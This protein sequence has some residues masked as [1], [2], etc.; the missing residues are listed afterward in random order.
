[1]REG[2]GRVG[3]ESIDD[4][5]VVIEPQVFQ[6]VRAVPTG[7]ADDN[8]TRWIRC[9]QRRHRPPGEVVPLLGIDIAH[10]VEQLE[11]HRRLVMVAPFKFEPQR[12]EAILQ[13][14]VVQKLHRLLN[15][16][17]IA[18]GLVQIEHHIHACALAPLNKGVNE[19]KGPLAIAAGLF[20]QHNLVEAQAY[21][22]HAEGRDV[23]HVI[24]ANVG[25]KMLEITRRQRPAPF[26]RQHIE[27]LVVGQPAANTH[28]MLKARKCFH[29]ALLSCFISFS[30]TDQTDRT[31]RTDQTDQTTISPI[32]RIRPIRRIS[33]PVVVPA[34]AVP[35]RR[36]G[37]SSGKS[38]LCSCCCAGSNAGRYFPARVHR[39][40]M[41][42]P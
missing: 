12:N 16:A 24:F 14:L 22:V 23:A 8:L 40:A 29:V 21:V 30:R 19:R 33:R 37:M 5:I 34:P 6:R 26:V 11:R 38:P 32:R 31:D 17:V 36:A 42:E 41:A 9:A 7:A 15:I 20:F 10:F 1:M 18:D 13:A 3:V 35:G 2:K 27:A 28:A 4:R 39:A 25:L